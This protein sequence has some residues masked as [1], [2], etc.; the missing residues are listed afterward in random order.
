MAV[1]PRASGPRQVARRL[2]CRHRAWQDG[3]RLCSPSDREPGDLAIRPYRA[4]RRRLATRRRAR[5]H[6]QAVMPGPLFRA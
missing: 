5:D 1:L 4:W 2:G 6:G 3:T